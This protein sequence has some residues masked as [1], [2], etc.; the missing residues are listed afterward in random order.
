M[1]LKDD[2]DASSALDRHFAN[3]LLAERLVVLAGLGTSRC[4]SASSGDP[5]APTMD[6][7]W[8]AARAWDEDD[9]TEILKEAGWPSASPRNDIELLLSRCQMALEL[10]PDKKL[11]EFIKKA[12]EMIVSKCRFVTAELDLGIHEAFMRKVARRSTTLPRTQLY[13]TNYDLAFEIAAAGMG[14]S[15]IDGFSHA[16][17]QRFDGSYFDHDFAIRDRE[18]ATAPIDWAPNVIQLH[19]LHGS[20]DW[21]RAPDGEVRKDASAKHPLIVYPRASKFE[22]SYQQPFLELMARFQA[23][24]RRPETGLMII[25]SGFNDDHISQPILAALR[26]NV[27]LTAVV[28]DP[29]L[30][31]SKNQH[32]ARVRELI[33]RGDRR[34]ALL[35][36][37]F[38]EAVERMPDFIALTE[39]EHHEARIAKSS[40]G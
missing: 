7:L 20:V 29:D 34:I 1:A 26:S 23:A 18:R 30:E 37:T 35:A 31:G 3:V 21:F 8:N 5:I 40:N 38:E 27:R 10:K 28:V 39:T 24:L 25:G 13:T 11:E 19:K 14:F 12:E 36:G 17:P 16:H 32:I 6:D 33:K 22:V 15:I 9:F 2:E 4:L